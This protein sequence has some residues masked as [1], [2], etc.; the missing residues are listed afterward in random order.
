MLFKSNSRNRSFSDLTT[1]L[2]DFTLR[3]NQSFRTKLK[4]SEILEKSKKLIKFI[5]KTFKRSTK[6]NYK[7]LPEMKVS[8]GI[9]AVQIREEYPDIDNVIRGII[10]THSQNGATIEDIKSKS[11]TFFI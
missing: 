8:H 7:N 5:Y 11:S 9:E 2:H 3:K 1:Q 6:T 4:S 10:L